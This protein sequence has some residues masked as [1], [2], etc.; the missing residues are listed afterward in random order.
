MTLAVTLLTLR[1]AVAVSLHL[2]GCAVVAEIVVDDVVVAVARPQSYANQ[3]GSMGN[4]HVDHR[5]DH[6]HGAR[7]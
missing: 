5:A 2:F 3:R 1:V 7:R 6:P 4:L